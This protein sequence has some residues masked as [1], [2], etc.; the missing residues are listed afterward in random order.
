MISGTLEF[1]AHER[2]SVARAEIKIYGVMNESTT[3]CTICAP[4]VA[5]IL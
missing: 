5:V 2:H 4:A 3:D 1:I